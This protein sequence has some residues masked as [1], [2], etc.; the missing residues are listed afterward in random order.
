MNDTQR[1]IPKVSLTGGCVL[2]KSIVSKLSRYLTSKIA[3][4]F[5]LKGIGVRQQIFEVSLFGLR[6]EIYLTKKLNL[7]AIKT[8]LSN[9]IL[10]I[11]PTNW[12]TP[13]Q[14]EFSSVF[15][16][17]FEGKSCTQKELRAQESQKDAIMKT[18][19]YIV[20]K[21]YGI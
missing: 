10:R 4:A 1:A 16:E 21:Q 15:G 20:G 12:G 13:T 18:R 3:D 5:T 14:L 9:R 11:R 19:K 2:I 7:Q 8:H 6:L 17:T